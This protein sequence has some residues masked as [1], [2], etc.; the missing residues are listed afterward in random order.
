M[1]NEDDIKRLV[2]VTYPVVSPPVGFRESLGER[3]SLE[4]GRFCGRGRS[5]AE[6]PPLW[7]PIAI[8]VISW[9][10]GYGTWLSLSVSMLT[11]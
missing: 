3:L 7:L 6:R 5:L 1:S 2:K 8:G 11:H 9:A 10:I 4:A